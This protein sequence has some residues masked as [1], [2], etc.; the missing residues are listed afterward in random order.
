LQNYPSARRMKQRAETIEGLSLRLSCLTLR[1]VN[2][3]RVCSP[4]TFILQPAVAVTVLGEVSVSGCCAWVWVLVHP[5]EST[6]LWP[7][8]LPSG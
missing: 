7:L 2:P 6:W 5:W 8:V 1:W 4:I 3:S